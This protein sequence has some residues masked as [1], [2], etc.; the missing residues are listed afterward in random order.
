MLFRFHE[1]SRSDLS[2]RANLAVLEDYAFVNQVFAAL[3]KD[4]ILQT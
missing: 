4:K 2:C 3:R 1:I